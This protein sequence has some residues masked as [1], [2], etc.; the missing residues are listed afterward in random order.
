MMNHKKVFYT[1]FLILTS[2]GVAL[3]QK[4]VSAAIQAAND[5][6]GAFFTSGDAA[7]LASLYTDDGRLLPPNH[8]VVTGHKNIQA[9]WGALMQAGIRAE[10]KTI[11]ALASGS[12]AVEEGMVKI[13]AGDMMVD[14]L[15]YVV[16]WKKIKGNWMIHQDIWNSSNPAPGE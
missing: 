12:T 14:E 9:F 4:D 13:Y 6:W 15:K 11:T 2:A 1:L 8:P 16:I 10:V 5:R 3:S 7:G